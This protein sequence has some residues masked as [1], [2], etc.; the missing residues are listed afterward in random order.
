[1]G[2][3][4]VTG[5]T[6]AT[7]AGGTPWVNPKSQL[8]KNAFLQLLVAQ[9]KN[10]DPLQP[11]DSTQ[12]I[13]QL[14]Q[15]SALEQMTNVAQSQSQALMATQM[16]AAAEWIGKGVSYVDDQGNTV[17]G[18]AQGVQLKDGAVYLDVGGV[19]V[20]WGSVVAVTSPAPGGSAGGP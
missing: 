6:S 5:G 12:F 9:L 19:S 11:M 8:D 7:G 2:D 1:M 13:S 16:Q 10:Q 20:P 17:S 3:M 18:L 15:F 4:V 14:A